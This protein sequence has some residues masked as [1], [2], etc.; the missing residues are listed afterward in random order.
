MNVRV[1]YSIICTY[2]H[3]RTGVFLTRAA[4]GS[5]CLAQNRHMSSNVATSFL[6]LYL[7]VRWNHWNS[8]ILACVHKYTY[9]ENISYVSHEFHLWHIQSHMELKQQLTAAKSVANSTELKELK[10][11]LKKSE[12]STAQLTD[13]YIHTYIHVHFLSLLLVCSYV[14]RT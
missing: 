7:K 6:E 9:M 5:Y 2:V 13:L 4:N 1:S 8:Y 10:E 3:V 12:V 11:T 14:H